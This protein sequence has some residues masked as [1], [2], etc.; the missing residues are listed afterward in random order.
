MD[1]LP[2]SRQIGGHGMDIG[3]K[4]RLVKAQNWSPGVPDG[5]TEIALPAP[6]V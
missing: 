4:R 2:S 3:S 1:V 6:L 5:D